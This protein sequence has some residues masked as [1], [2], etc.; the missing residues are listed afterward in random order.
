MVEGADTKLDLIAGDVDAVMLQL[1]TIRFEGADELVL[2]ELCDPVIGR[3]YYHL[4][5]FE[6]RNLDKDLWLCAV[7]RFV[8]NAI[9]E[10][11]YIRRV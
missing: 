8:F 5:Q 6:N 3:G 7:T 9:L 10:K 4:T 11:I 2:R 1:D